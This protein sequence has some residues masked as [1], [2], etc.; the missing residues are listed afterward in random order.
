MSESE[1]ECDDFEVFPS[2]EEKG[3]TWAG[4]TGT[5]TKI[6]VGLKFN[7]DG[8]ISHMYTFNFLGRPMKKKI[9]FHENSI[10][11]VIGH[12]SLGGM[13][14]GLAISYSADDIVRA[15]GFYKNGSQH[16]LWR[17]FD[18][19]TNAFT[20]DGSDNFHIKAHYR[21]GNKHGLCG[22]YDVDSYAPYYETIYVNGVYNP[23]HNNGRWKNVRHDLYTQ[24][25]RPGHLW[26][27]LIFI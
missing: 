8:Q 7:D 20:I 22:A 10:Y 17:I 3:W 2:A 5:P 24:L 11:K 14:E 16:G 15:Y 27:Y 25:L 21:D 12:A 18:Y 13:K 19:K 23:L 4:L 26:Y 1:D 9:Q 6:G